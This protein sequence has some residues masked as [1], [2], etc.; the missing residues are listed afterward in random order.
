ME[1][2]SVPP[3]EAVNR[4]ALIKAAAVINRTGTLGAR[5]E[6]V[7]SIDP[8]SLQAVMHVVNRNTRDVIQELPPEHVLRI[9]A[10]AIRPL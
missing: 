9:A 7:F 3:T 4:R 1:A 2:A 6:L 5:N 8:A 10:D